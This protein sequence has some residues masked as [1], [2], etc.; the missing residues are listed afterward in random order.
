M[1]DEAH[2]LMPVHWE[3]AAQNLPQELRNILFITVHPQSVASSVLATVDT[4]IAVG[5]D[6]ADTLAGFGRSAGAEV[7][8]GVPDSVP[9]G[10]AVCWRAAAGEVVVFEVAKSR[11]ERRRH[12]RKYAEGDLG[13]RGAFYFTGPDGNLNLK[14]QNLMLFLQIA[15]GVDDETWAFHLGRGDYSGWFRTHIKDDDLA[16]AAGEVEQAAGD[17]APQESRTRIR[18]I[19]EERYTLPD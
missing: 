3:R 19:V 16:A 18:A 15:E 7:P 10:H 8:E 17:L 12:V 13:E 1:I 9:A 14:A 6:P 5:D 4:V 2:H 11:Q